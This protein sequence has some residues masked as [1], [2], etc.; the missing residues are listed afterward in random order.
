VSGPEPAAPIDVALGGGATAPER[1]DPAG[2]DRS[3]PAPPRRGR[4]GGVSVIAGGLLQDL[5][6][7][8]RR[9]LAPIEERVRPGE[10]TRGLVGGAGGPSGDPA[11][12][13]VI[14]LPDHR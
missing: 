5:E 13:L 2:A 11:D 14:V 4:S 3:A 1:S 7:R 10:E 6:D 12:P 9:D 8:L